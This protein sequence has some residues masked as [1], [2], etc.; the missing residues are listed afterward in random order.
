MRR[1]ATRPRFSISTKAGVLRLLPILYARVSIPRA[2]ADELSRGLEIG[3]D[4]P[5]F[6]NLS[7]LRIRELD[8]PH[9]LSL[10]AELGSGEQEV[11]ALG[12]RMPGT[13]IVMDER[14]CRL[15][16]ETLKLTC[17]G[18]LGILLRAKRAGHISRVLPILE[19]L[20]SLGFRLSG[21]TYSAVALLA[22][23]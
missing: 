18:T 4:L 14:R 9:R 5:D 20:N 7:W 22:G 17:T 23:E 1:S 12:L 13:V 2:V 11:L 16:A 8:P 21:K 15:H 19:R 6:R 3:V 10:T